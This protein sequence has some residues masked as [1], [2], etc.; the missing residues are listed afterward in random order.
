M[1]RG[2]G[3]GL[4]LGQCRSDKASDGALMHDD[5]SMLIQPLVRI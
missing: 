5:Q 4:K 1:D 2:G 3:T